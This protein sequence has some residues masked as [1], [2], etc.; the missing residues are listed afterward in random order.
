M[1]DIYVFIAALCTEDMLCLYDAS[2]KEKKCSKE[3]Q[4]TFTL[5]THWVCLPFGNILNLGID[6][7][8]SGLKNGV[9]FRLRYWVG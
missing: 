7:T 9:F 3:K 5:M 1:G 4:Q 8:D 6:N 2:P